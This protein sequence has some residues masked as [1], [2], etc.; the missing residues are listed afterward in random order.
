LRKIVAS[1]KRFD[2][3]EDALLGVSCT[4][5]KGHINIDDTEVIG[6]VW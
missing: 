1:D 2:Q 5:E 4:S 3:G 6:L